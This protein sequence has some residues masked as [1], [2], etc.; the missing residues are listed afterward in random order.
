MECH[1]QRER[2]NA[3][4]LINAQMGRWLAEHGVNLAIA[5]AGQNFSCSHINRE[6]EDSSPS[7]HYY[8]DKE[9][10]HCF[11]CEMDGDLIDLMMRE[12]DCDYTTA[13]EKGAAWAGFSYSRTSGPSLVGVPRE[14]QAPTLE[15]HS[16]PWVDSWIRDN[17]EVGTRE[18]SPSVGDDDTSELVSSCGLDDE[19]AASYLR[20]RG[21]EPETAAMHGVRYDGSWVHPANVERGRN[22]PPSRRIIVPTGPESYLARAVDGSVGEQY[23]KQ[24]VGKQESFFGWESV[25]EA[26]TRRLP[27]WVVEGEFDALSLMQCGALAVALGSTSRTTA[28]CD[29]MPHGYGSPVLLML[30]HDKA[31]MAATDKAVPLLKARGIP[32]V[33]DL[34]EIMDGL[35]HE[36]MGDRDYDPNDLVLA[37]GR[38]GMTETVRQFVASFAPM[39]TGGAD[40]DKPDGEAGGTRGAVSAR[41]Y[42]DLFLSGDIAEFSRG[43]GRRWG[44]KNMDDA[45]GDVRCGLYVLGGAPSV[46]KT[47]LAHQIA[48]NLASQHVPV[49]FISLEQTPLELVSKSVAREVAKKIGGD[50]AN[51]TSLRF[52]TGRG[53]DFANDCLAEYARDTAPWLHIVKGGIDG[54][55]ALDIE[56]AT[57][58][59]VRGADADVRPVVVIDYLQLV[60]GSDPRMSDKQAADEVSHTL[61]RISVDYSAT[62]IAISSFNR[63]SYYTVS[64]M[65]NFKESG[66]IEYSADVVM[67]LQVSAIDK[68]KSGSSYE[69]D[70]RRKV[71]EAAERETPRRVTLDVLKNRYGARRQK[72]YFD[73]YPASDYFEPSDASRAYAGM[74]DEA[75]GASPAPSAGVVGCDGVIEFVEPP[76]GLT[77]RRKGKK[78]PSPI[79]AEEQ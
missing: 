52:R 73:Y 60:K 53:G 74:D 5:E 47:T 41:D 8:P 24:K 79:D 71:V 55:T 30:D 67:G 50:K 34:A 63:E 40:E 57:A 35:Y 31:G 20:S 56:A 38:D 1:D 27:L 14:S 32:A 21:I 18:Q 29:A 76:V 78:K 75:D 61:K 66:G 3:K 17:S 43:S 12:W 59:W 44:M 13:L 77:K 6:H 2:D 16:D 7:C 51:V 62:V 48:D 68:F 54:T 58:A 4:K 42:I 28:F 9:R 36:V 26:E 45:L 33:S 69:K 65:G 72:V 37:V 70:K 39:A 10:V 49:L 22:V 23:R 64:D 19:F 15:L 25:A 11:G 46:G